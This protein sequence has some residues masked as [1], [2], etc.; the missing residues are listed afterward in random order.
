MRQ[1]R[2]KNQEMRRHWARL[3][4][5]TMTRRM[6]TMDL[7]LW[8]RMMSR[9]WSNSVSMTLFR[10][11]LLRQVTG[12][13]TPLVC[14]FQHASLKERLTWPFT[15]KA[16]CV[17]QQSKAFAC[18]ITN[19]A[20]NGIHHG[21]T[22]IVL[23][24]GAKSEVNVWRSLLRFQRCGSGLFKRIHMITM[25]NSICQSWRMLWLMLASPAFWKDVFGRCFTNSLRGSY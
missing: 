18:H 21:P 22:E 10:W 23:L 4:K 14:T 5:M 24:H 1:I 19:V 3:V 8:R 9:D 20:C 6:E 25:H 17:C 16:W 2:V 15:A 13:T 7:C 12:T 11:C